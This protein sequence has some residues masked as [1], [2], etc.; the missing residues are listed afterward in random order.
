MAGVHRP[1]EKTPAKK[2]LDDF[3]VFLSNLNGQYRL[4]IHASDSK[5]TARERRTNANSDP[6]AER[7]GKIQ[8]RLRYLFF[9]ERTVLQGILDQLHRCAANSS[10]TRLHERGAFPGTLS[11]PQE[12]STAHV[13]P[14]TETEFLQ[15]TLYDLLSQAW[16]VHG[17]LDRSFGTIHKAETDAGGRPYKRNS[18]GVYPEAPNRGYK[19][20]RQQEGDPDA[21]DDVP[22]RTRTVT[23]PFEASV[24]KVTASR[25]PFFFHQPQKSSHSFYN[26]SAN[27]SNTTFTSSVFSRPQ[28]DDD[29]LQGSQSTV[30]ASSQERTRGD[31]LP[32]LQ[33]SSRQ[34]DAAS[35]A[36]KLLQD[37]LSKH[38]ESFAQFDKPSSKHHREDHVANQHRLFA[39]DDFQNSET[40]GPES[41]F[42][43]KER[44][45]KV[46]PRLPKFLNQAPL[47]VCWE[48]TRIALHCGVDLEHL[49]DLCYSDRWVDQQTLRTELY[50][51]SPFQGKAFPEPCPEATWTAGNGNF[52]GPKSRAVCLSIDLSWNTNPTGPLFNVSLQPLKLD[53]GHRLGRRFGSD[54]FL[55]MNFP[56]FTATGVPPQ[57]KRLNGATDTIIK[58][59]TTEKHFLAGRQWAAFFTRDVDKVAAGLAQ[60]LAAWEGKATTKTRL[61]QC[62]VCCFA[63]DGHS[64]SPGN[65]IPAKADAKKANERIKMKLTEML[66]WAIAIRANAAQP[67]L[68]LFSRLALSLSRTYPTII[69]EPGQIIHH[70]EDI[71]SKSG[72]VMND[73]VAEM[74]PKAAKAIA[75]YLG[76]TDTPSAYQGRFGSAK[77]VWIVGTDPENKDD[78]EIET[79][80]SQRKWECD[81]WDEDHRTFEVKT[82][83]R[84]LRAANLNM[85]FIPVLVNGDVKRGTDK[86]RM[87]NA[88]AKCLRTTLKEELARQRSSMDDPVQFRQWIHESF[89]QGYRNDRLR[90]QNIRFLAGLPDNEA[91]RVN[92]LLDAGFQP[93]KLSFL[94]DMSYK[95]AFRKCELLKSKMNI[96]VGCSTY[97]KMVVD[98]KG[99]LEEGEIHLGFSTKFMDPDGQFSDTLLH[100]MD[101]LV[102]RAPAHFP[103][104][105]QRVR[106]VFRSEL[107]HLKDVI[108]FS[109][110][111][112]SPL[113]DLLSGGDYDGDQAW[114]CWDSTIVNSFQNVAYP[115]VP[116]LFALGYLEKRKGTFQ[117]LVQKNSSNMDRAVAEFM[118]ESFTFNMKEQFLGICTAYKERLCYDYNGI[119]NS[120]AVALSHLVGHLVDQAKQGIVFGRDQWVRFCKG[121]LKNGLQDLPEPRYKAETGVNRNQRSSKDGRL[122]EEHVLDYLKFRVALPLVDQEMEA[123][124]SLLGNEA[125]TFDKDLLGPFDDFERLMKTSMSLGAKRPEPSCFKM[126][127]DYLT[128]EIRTIRQQWSNIP[129]AGG[130]Y[131]EAVQA[132]HNQWQS[133]EVPESASGN[134]QLTMYL[135]AGSSAPPFDT[136]TLLKASTTFKEYYRSSSSFVWNIAG[137]QL[138]WIKASSC[139]KGPAGPVAVT[140]SMYAI[141]RPDSGLVKGIMA[142]KCSADGQSVVL[143]DVEYDEDGT[144]IDDA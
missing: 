83:A 75:E 142:K 137:R 64:F 90:D 103:S 121:L 43:L 71:C 132:I 122:G 55:E 123:F 39:E 100:G 31:S 85:Q 131:T 93:K 40:T 134:E 124:N 78:F 114:V 94:R 65:R 61:K 5:L 118:F 80:P 143:D 1:K 144:Q 7:V 91:E 97:A 48:V 9:K 56:S 35:D 49:T 47:A 99:V 34:Y 33:C 105:I 54:R 51:H 36:V 87:R 32:N 76:L 15:T 135:A 18:A 82:E 20:S 138:A 42:D 133:L 125:I 58:W 46:W 59:L 63:E 77:G 107:R 25:A 8:E 101:V 60:G 28:E 23:S 96:K 120:D 50:K 95:M 3:P 89:F 70:A 112:D 119:D 73:G 117:D 136:W 109:I 57:I 22:V 81:F 86:H 104:D 19:R 106:A 92:L 62:R 26:R 4:G 129:K 24:D 79:Y 11:L 17:P 30:E 141:L 88:I 53:L 74:S 2:R 130:K 27:T 10:N 45:R 52:E 126:I 21:L 127:N 84:P 69:F 108:V 139:P 102:A 29:A 98:F 38:Q 13:G 67:S 44:L 140:S 113:A 6:Q 72:K 41:L 68:K 16:K 66:E 12:P 116:D 128:A 110:K 111:G 14:N 37:S 115:V